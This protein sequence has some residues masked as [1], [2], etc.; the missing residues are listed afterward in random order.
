MSLSFRKK[1]KFL[2]DE[3]ITLFCGNFFFFL[4]FLQFNFPFFLEKI[5][6]KSEKE[7]SMKSQ[8]DTLVFFY[9]FFRYLTLFFTS[10]FLLC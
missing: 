5:I 6:E 2:G 10:Y 3:I 8:I 7:I 1:K 4:L 9:K